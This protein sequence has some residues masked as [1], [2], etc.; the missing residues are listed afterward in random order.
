MNRINVEKLFEKF[1]RDIKEQTSYYMDSVRTLN[2]PDARAIASENYVLSSAV[3]F[4]RF[5]NDLMLA[6]INNDCRKFSSHI[7][8]SIES[9]LKPHSKTLNG[10]RHFGVFSRKNNI[11]KSDLERILYPLG[12][13]DSLY[14]Y[15][16]I[17]KRAKKWL[18]ESH[19]MKFHMVHQEKRTIVD[20]LIAFRNDLAHS[21]PGSRKKLILLLRKKEL[22]TTNLQLNKNSFKNAG[23]YLRVKPSGTNDTRARY[24]IRTITEVARDLVF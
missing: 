22:L 15:N 5:I 21:S 6:Y 4:E 14:S 10:Y 3:L 12:R 16:T 7:E 13:I 11:K 19:Y 1:D 17:Q 8:A 18:N 2:H 20:V 23:A 9:C 24:L